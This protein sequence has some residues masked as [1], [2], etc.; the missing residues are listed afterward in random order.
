MVLGMQ[1]C[2]LAHAGMG[3][4]GIAVLHHDKSQDD[5]MILQADGMII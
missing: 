3:T 2:V 4:V 5:V 1:V